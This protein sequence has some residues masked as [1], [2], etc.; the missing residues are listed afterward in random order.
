[1]NLKT[2]RM[3][4]YTP[5]ILSFQNFTTSALLM[6][7]HY[8]KESFIFH[9]RGSDRGYPRIARSNLE[10]CTERWRPHPFGSDP[11]IGR[12]GFLVGPYWCL[13]SD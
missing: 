10:T 11:S 3:K 13:D 9:C 4:Y 12:N 8:A 1:M 2:T 6:K 5:T 7:K